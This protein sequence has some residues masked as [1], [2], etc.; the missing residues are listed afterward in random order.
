MSGA[1]R[2]RVDRLGEPRHAA[3]E[4]ARDERGDIAPPSDLAEVSAPQWSPLAMSGAT[5]LGTLN[6]TPRS[7]AAM[8]PARDERGDLA[9]GRRGIQV[10]RGR[11][12]AR[13]R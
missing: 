5:R 11:N 6:A 4:P 3:M 13:S 12:G 9:H 10:W 1:T 8:E 7:E 2:D